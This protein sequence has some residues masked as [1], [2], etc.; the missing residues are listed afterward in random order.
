VKAPEGYTW[1]SWFGGKAIP[2][3]V[4]TPFLV[5]KLAALFAHGRAFLEEDR[6]TSLLPE[7]MIDT[8]T[9]AFFLL[10]VLAYLTRSRALSPGTGFRERVFPIL[11]VTATVAGVSCL[12]WL[13]RP[14]LFHG[15][16]LG[17]VLTASGLT[18]SVWS[19]SHLR[20]SFS[21]MAEARRLVTSGPYRWVRHPLYLGE[22]LTMLG[23]CFEIGTL[24]ALLF[25]TLVTAF[26]LQRAR[27]E[28]EKLSRQFAEHGAYRQTSYFILP[29]IY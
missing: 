13:S 24:E 16:W 14:R 3:T 7:F 12:Q 4:W 19:L 29:G 15:V 28:E 17:V 2:L 10:L 11:V 23:L 1:R 25:W 6:S 20:R 9:V 26:Q 21:I 5:A 18:I 27:I 8:L 22:A